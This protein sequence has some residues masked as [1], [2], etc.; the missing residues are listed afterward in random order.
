MTTVQDIC[1]DALK[2]IRRVSLGETPSGQLASHA[3]TRLN[4]MLYSWKS[5]HID[6]L[7]DA[8]FALA[9]TFVFFVPPAVLEW[10]TLDAL[11]YQGTWDAS[12]NSPTLASGTGTDGH[13][14]KVATAGSTTLDSV[15]SW[16]VNDFAVYDG[17][18]CV[19]RK[20]LSS[21]R[22]EGGIKALLAMNMAADFGV[23]PIAGT[24]ELAS[25]GMRDLEAAFIRPPSSQNFDS[26]LVRA[27][28]NRY[29]SYISSDYDG[30]S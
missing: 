26:A 10:Q 29:Q 8:D 16:A 4:D 21:R 15:T 12:A 18:R 6:L 2:R 13:V 3:L 19:W 9:D 17:Y 5:D 1:T 14:Y 23:Q 22:F 30:S 7:L 20:G 28:S 24:A 27:P 25:D 11:E